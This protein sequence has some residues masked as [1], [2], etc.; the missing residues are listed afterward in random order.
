[1]KT[2]QN[3]KNIISGNTEVEEITFNLRGNSKIGYDFKVN[4]KTLLTIEPRFSND[5]Y[6]WFV[7]GELFIN[8]AEHFKNINQVKKAL[9]VI[10]SKI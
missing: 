8:G 7:Y 1:M 5:G 4:N 10:K 6:K 9:I 3:I 2:I